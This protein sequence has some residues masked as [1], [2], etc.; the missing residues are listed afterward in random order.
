MRTIKYLCYL[1]AAI[2]CLAFAVTD[3]YNR[4]LVTAAIFAVAGLLIVVAFLIEE[5]LTH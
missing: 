1:F 2:V 5:A 4:E 3:L